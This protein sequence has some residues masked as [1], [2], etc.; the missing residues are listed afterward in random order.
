MKRAHALLGR[1]KSHSSAT[2]LMGSSG[3][4]S[5]SN[6][7][8]RGGGGAAPQQVVMS[9]QKEEREQEEQAMA[10]FLEMIEDVNFP[11][12][13]RGKLLLLPQSHKMLLVKQWRQV[14]EKERLSVNDPTNYNYDNNEGQQGD[15]TYNYNYNYDTYDENNEGYYNEEGAAY[16]EGQEGQEG[17]VTLR[18]DLYP[19]AGEDE[20]PGARG[21]RM[22]YN[23]MKTGAYALL[24][25]EW[26]VEGGGA[27]GGGED[28]NNNNGNG[29]EGEQERGEVSGAQGEGVDSTTLMLG[30]SMVFNSMMAKGANRLVAP[31]VNEDLTASSSYTT[32]S[33]SSSTSSLS[34]SPWGSQDEFSREEFEEQELE[35][36]TNNNNNNK[37]RDGEKGQEKE[38]DKDK[39]SKTR[40]KSRS[41]TKKKSRKKDSKTK[42]RD[43]EKDKDEK[44]KSSEKAI[45]KKEVVVGVVGVERAVESGEGEGGGGLDAHVRQ[46]LADFPPSAGYDQLFIKE[47][48]TNFEILRELSKADL[49]SLGIPMGHCVA[50][51][52]NVAQIERSLKMSTATAATITPG[53]VVS[54]GR[55]EEGKDVPTFAQTPAA[56]VDNSGGSYSPIGIGAAK[57]T[58]DNTNNATNNNNPKKQNSS[59]SL[60]GNYGTIK[61]DPELIQKTKAALGGTQLFLFLLLSNI[62]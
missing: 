32:S 42:E 3:G 10:E 56:I 44:N 62:S 28:N 22:F 5:E 47:A 57:L 20:T 55:K 8:P 21:T 23:L 4:K 30:A 31:T 36:D 12:E 39:D 33:T 2:N 35:G 41:K 34:I 61:A 48:I 6:T 37:A 46:V 29:N 49:K 16:G 60:E 52:K 11:K 25:E 27:G 15:D 59:E 50:I 54:P 24:T 13:Q 45:D 19:P 53:P 51:L 18:A 43:A 1:F 7:T 14:K 9:T 26:G 58:L 38:K 17:E 40:P